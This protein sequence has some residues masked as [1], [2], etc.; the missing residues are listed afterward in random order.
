M[1]GLL[2]VLGVLPR[3]LVL[4]AFG[5]YLFNSLYVDDVIAPFL[6][7]WDEE[8]KEHEM[9][10]LA[11]K[12]KGQDLMNDQHPGS[13]AVAVIIV[14]DFVCLHRRNIANVEGDT[15]YRYIRL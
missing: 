9:N 1:K 13:G 14:L 6:Q 3:L 7:E 12:Q 15:I 10:F 5:G 2:S 4:L 8:S 11:I